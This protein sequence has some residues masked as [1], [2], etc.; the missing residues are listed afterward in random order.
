M[1]SPKNLKVVFWGTYDTGKPRNRIIL[2]GLAEYGATVYECHKSIW[3][4]VEDKTQITGLLFYLKILVRWLCAYPPLIFN[5]FKQPSHDVIFVGYLGQL[6]VLILWPFAKLR[7]KPIVLDVFISLYDSIVF[8]RC[9]V[10]PHNP[11]AWAIYILEWIAFR[12][13]DMVLID[14]EA[15]RQYLVDTFRL[16]PSKTGKVFVGVEPEFFPF[17][18]DGTDTSH[19]EQHKLFTF[20]FY[21]QFIPLHGIPTIIEAARIIE[22]NPVEIIIIGRGQESGKVSDMLKEVPLTC[23]NWI[24]WVE[25]EMLSRFIQSSDICLGIFGN[26]EKAGRVIPNKVYQILHS[27]KPIITRDSPA[28]RELLTPDQPGVILVPPAD[29]KSL[30]KQMLKLF[31]MKRVNLKCKFHNSVKNQIT[32]LAIG[33][34]TAKHLNNVV[35]GCS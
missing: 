23:I 21:G 10:G 33:R 19:L 25:Y 8:D 9:L 32:P 2:R 13:A 16:K 12:A 3:E 20:L 29:P 15:H 34:E 11:I 7:G 14:T 28:I 30:A 26:S 1:T 31:E 5:Y 27:G 22:G 17:P 18:V 4:N 6:D 24:P 35:E